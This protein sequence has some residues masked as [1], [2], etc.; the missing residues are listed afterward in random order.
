LTLGIRHEPAHSYP[1]VLFRLTIG[2]LHAQVGPGCTI[3]GQA[4]DRGPDRRAEVVELA[5]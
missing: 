5:E 1:S 4:V 3:L 2:L